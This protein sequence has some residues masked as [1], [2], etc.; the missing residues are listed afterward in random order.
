MCA[1]FG[2]ESSA[3]KILKCLDTN[4]H[5]NYTEG[6]IYLNVLRFTTASCK[7][8]LKLSCLLMSE[9]KIRSNTTSIS[10]LH[11]LIFHG[12]IRSEA[13]ISQ[14]YLSL[15]YIGISILT[16]MRACCFLLP[17]KSFALHS[18]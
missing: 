18:S 2:V 15:V 7:Y 11:K 17:N 13:D 8:T 16:V 5:L 3:L 12:D 4:L 9:F 10:A 14:C 6:V 1:A